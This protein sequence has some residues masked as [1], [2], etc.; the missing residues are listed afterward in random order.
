MKLSASAAGCLP[1]EEAEAEG[2]SM[3]LMV[4]GFSPSPDW[5]G[6]GRMKENQNLMND[7]GH[8]KSVLCDN[9]EGWGGS[10]Q[11]GRV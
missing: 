5:G 9:L 3:W 11:R 4:G 10:G 8:P 2:L 1:W 6:R 7:S